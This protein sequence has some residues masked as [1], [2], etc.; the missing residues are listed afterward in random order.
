MK[1]ISGRAG[2]FKTKYCTGQV[3]CFSREILDTLHNILN[4]SL[5][6]IPRA[7][8]FP[9]F[10]CLYSLSLLMKTNSMVEILKLIEKESSVEESTFEL[11]FSDQMK[12]IAHIVD[13]YTFSFFDKYNILLCPINIKSKLAVHCLNVICSKLEDRSIISL[14][15]FF[16]AHLESL[17]PPNT[18]EQALLLEEIY[19]VCS[20]YMWLSYRI[21]KYF[22]FTEDCK[23]MRSKL[24]EW[25]TDFFKKQS[26]NSTLTPNASC[27]SQKPSECL[28]AM[29]KDQ[30]K[31]PMNNKDKK[32]TNLYQ[33]EQ[34]SQNKIK[35]AVE[36]MGKMKNNQKNSRNDASTQINK[37]RKK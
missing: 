22:I 9:D 30:K 6:S 7:I 12:Y 29:K 15:D 17:R 14:D 1:Q 3:T 25:M 11:F 24:E 36:K 16:E 26:F 5:E 18:G 28:E 4:K 32:T 2:R 21:K 37:I 31:I 35:K 13:N 27:V 8:I 20:V 10:D 23:L 19:D 33:N 34:I